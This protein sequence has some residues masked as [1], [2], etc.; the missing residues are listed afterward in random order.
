MLSELG[1]SEEVA[2]EICSDPFNKLKT[3]VN[4]LEINVTTK[5]TSV[6]VTKRVKTRQGRPDSETFASVKEIMCTAP[7]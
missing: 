6:K 4:D 1:L 5:S 3:L 7:V 2:A